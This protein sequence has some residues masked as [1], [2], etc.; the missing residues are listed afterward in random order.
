V[1]TINHYILREI[2]VPFL[3]GLGVFTMV[4]LIARILKLVEMV[5]NRGVPFADVLRLFSYI[6][7]AFLEVTVPMALLLAVLIGFGRL[8][9]DSEITALK[10]SGV[11]LYQLL[12]P[13]AV[14]AFLVYAV[15]LAVSVYARPWGNARL[16]NA[17]YEI[18]KTRASAGI[19]EKVFF[20]E[21]AGLVIYV[22]RIEP[23]GN[24]LRGILIA[25]NRDPAQRNTVFAKVG[26]LVPNEPLHTLTL[27]LLDGSVHAFYQNDKSYHR[28]DFTTYDISLDLNA[29]LA[30]M[31]P[32]DRDPRELPL[33]ELTGLI[34]R[35]H[36][37][38]DPAYV[39]QV[40]WHRR[41]SVPFA[42]LGFAAIAI[43]LGVRPSFAV[44]SRGFAISIAL[45]FFYYVLLSLGDNLGSRGLL[46]P[47]FALWIPNICLTMLAVVLFVGAAEER[48]A[49]YSHRLAGWVSALRTRFAALAT[50]GA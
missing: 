27:R 15:A 41:F 49:P 39:D 38:G 40:E 43:P 9:S 22:D 18:A 33:M 50:R 24:T 34:A 8:S 47:W 32:P 35:K 4:L 45:I 10:T 17:L 31:K 46:P 11:S 6:V 23:P 25:D 1:R 14:F 5:V 16:R 37:A 26:F 36:A 7:P 20:D 42:C 21:F 28:T 48:P 29:A 12:R 13:V 3:L 30:K 2:S 19:K 44:R